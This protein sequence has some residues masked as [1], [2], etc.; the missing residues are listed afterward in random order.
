MLGHVRAK[1]L[2]D[3]KEALDKAIEREGFAV[4]VHDCT[5]SFMLKFDKGC[6]GMHMCVLILYSLFGVYFAR[7]C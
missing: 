7:G 2:N 6:E 3:F 4:A 5:Q 1:T